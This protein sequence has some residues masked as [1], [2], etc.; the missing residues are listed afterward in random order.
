MRKYLFLLTLTI[1][2]FVFGQQSLQTHSDTLNWTIDEYYRLNLKIFQAEST[3]QDIDSL[4]TLF[5]S[6]FTYVHPKYGGTYTREDLYNG[7]SNNRKNGGYNGRVVNIKLLNRI[8]G[9]NAVTTQKQFVTQDNGVLTEGEKE[10]TLFEFSEG[11]I[12]RIFEY[13]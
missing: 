3:Q 2:G 4:F 10:M 5:T 9:L 7:Y 12:S 6:D 8:V 1:S 11:K 13:W